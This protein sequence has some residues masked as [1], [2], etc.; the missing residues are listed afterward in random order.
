M[1]SSLAWSATAQYHILDGLNNRNVF[2]HN[3]G[4]SKSKK[5]V[6]L[7]LVSSEACLLIWQM[8]TFLV[9][10]CGLSSVRAQVCVQTASS[11]KGSSHIGL[12]P[13]QVTLLYLNHFFKGPDLQTHS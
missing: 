13:T 2:S 12:G 3:S 4:G 9:S 8:A 7:A 5:K 1:L 6:S 11:Y 10:S